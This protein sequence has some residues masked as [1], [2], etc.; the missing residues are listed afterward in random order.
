MLLHSCKKKVFQSSNSSNHEGET[1]KSGRY[2][3]DSFR[4]SSKSLP[5]PSR[6]ASIG[7][8]TLFLCKRS[9]GEAPDSPFVLGGGAVPVRVAFVSVRRTR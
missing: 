5:T 6:D 8:I 2:E 1:V 4:A 7:P 9:A 3:V